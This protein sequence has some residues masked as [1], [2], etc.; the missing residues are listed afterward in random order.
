MEK[1][2]KLYGYAV[3]YRSKYKNIKISGYSKYE[4]CG[5]CK[6]ERYNNKVYETEEI[7]KRAIEE[8]PYYKSE[9]GFMNDYKIIPLYELQLSEQIKV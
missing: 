6:Y 1:N 5:Y 7:A 9:T 4:I 3:E 8:N 2:Y